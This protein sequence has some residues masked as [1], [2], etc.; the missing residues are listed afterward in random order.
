MSRCFAPRHGTRLSRAAPSEQNRVF[1][2]H[3]GGLIRAARFAS[4]LASW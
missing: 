1:P 2:H 4:G 3:P